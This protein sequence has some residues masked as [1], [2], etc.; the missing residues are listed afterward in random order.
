MTFEIT[1]ISRIVA[2]PYQGKIKINQ[3][4]IALD[5]GPGLK[6]DM[7]NDPVTHKLTKNGCL[8]AASTFIHGLS[9]VIKLGEAGGFFSRDEIK[10][11][12][13]AEL[14]KSVEAP[15]SIEQPEYKSLK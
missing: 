4:E 3:V 10:T 12:L 7:Y 5:L 2:E 13:L 14:D 8:S 11:L 15:G 6:K 9:M 1:G